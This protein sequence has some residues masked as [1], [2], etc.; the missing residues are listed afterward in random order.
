MFSLGQDFVVESQHGIIRCVAKS[1]QAASAFKVLQIALAK[2]LP[3]LPEPP[4]VEIS[5]D[6]VIGPSTTLAVQVVIQRLCEGSHQELAPI[7]LAQ[8]EEAIPAVAA[9]A[10]EIAGYLDRVLGDDPSA[11]LAPKPIVEPEIDP[12]AVLRQIFTGK[13]IAAL[14]ATVLGLGGLALV[15]GASDRRAL[16]YMD[17]AGFLPESDGTDEFEEDTDEEEEI[18]PEP[19]EIEPEPEPE[20]L[21]EPIEI[22]EIDEPEPEQPSA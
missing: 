2:L 11:I 1:P 15:A 22:D 4:P 16:G 6:G 13:R 12:V 17:R 9:S 21:P 18:D 7:A 10:M 3:Q 14:G 8:P 20:P 19:I 5:V